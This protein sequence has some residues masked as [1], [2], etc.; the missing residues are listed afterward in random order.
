M[1][2]EGIMEMYRERTCFN[3]TRPAMLRQ[4][5]F[6]ASIREYPVQLRGCIPVERF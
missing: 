3:S 2:Y 1:P 5:L 6:E 4:E